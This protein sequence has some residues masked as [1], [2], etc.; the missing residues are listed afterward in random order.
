MIGT[1][2]EMCRRQGVLQQHGN[3]H[4]AHAARDRS[5]RASYVR[6]GRMHISSKDESAPIEFLLSLRL[7]TIEAADVL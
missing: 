4:G 5:Q 7:K 6:Y 3:S 1:L 2:G